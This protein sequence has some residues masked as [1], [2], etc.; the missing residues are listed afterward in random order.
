ME[1]LKLEKVNN[2]PS[3]KCKCKDD[4]FM[5]QIWLMEFDAVISSNKTS[6]YEVVQS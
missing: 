6:S 3:E 1:W 5:W 4:V 2:W